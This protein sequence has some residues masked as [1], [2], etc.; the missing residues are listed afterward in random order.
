[1]FDGPVDPVWIED[2]NSV[3]DDNKKL[4]LPSGEI[5]KFTD[6]RWVLRR[7]SV[8]YFFLICFNSD[9][10]CLSPIGDDGDV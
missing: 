5:I 6:V 4:C 2:M 3:L 1:M 8:M 10:L 7:C 9:M